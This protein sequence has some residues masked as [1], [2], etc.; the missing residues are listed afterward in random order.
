[1]AEFVSNSIDNLS[2]GLTV[3]SAMEKL[4]LR[5]YVFRMVLYKTPFLLWVCSM[6]DLL[7]GLEIRLM[8]HQIIG[9]QW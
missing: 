6:K 2:H 4:K 3:K 7:P 5:E 9:V 1:M 8:A